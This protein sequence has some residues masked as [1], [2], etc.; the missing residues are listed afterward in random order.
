[1]AEDEIARLKR[2]YERYDAQP[3]VGRDNPGERLIHEDRDRRVLASLERWSRD[4]RSL[5][6]L[7]LGCGVGRLLGT[8]A[9]WGASPTRL[10]GVDLM[11]ARIEAARASFPQIRF[12]VTNAERLPFD[13]GAFDLVCCFTVF[14]SILDEV[15]AAG[16]AAEVRRV[17]QPGGAV[18]WYDLRYDNPANPNVRGLTSHALRTLFPGFELDVRPTT[19]LPPLARR[20]GP[21]TRFLYPCLSALPPL[22]THYLGLLRSTGAGRR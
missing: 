17:L 1:M 14:S 11:P 12:E 10:T 20:L 8:L 13:D 6:V 3:R 5:R 18:V 9:G 7:D 15:T 4:W 19:V 22:N 16:V 21:L 2:T